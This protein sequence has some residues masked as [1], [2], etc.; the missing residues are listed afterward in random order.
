MEDFD[1][2]DVSFDSSD[3]SSSDEDDDDQQE[4]LRELRKIK[5][6][7]AA[8]KKQQVHKY[9]LMRRT[10]GAISR[11]L[12]RGF[13]IKFLRQLTL[14]QEL[15][16]MENEKKSQEEAMLAG[17]PL[18]AA[19]GGAGLKRRFVISLWRPVSY[20]SKIAYRRLKNKNKT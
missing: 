7:R 12:L 15:Q 6:E 11:V 19:A 3:S 18:L 1:D 14:L 13:R 20:S 5:K 17:N 4:L 9:D 10:C 2:S 16:R 8:E